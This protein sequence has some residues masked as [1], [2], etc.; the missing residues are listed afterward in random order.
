MAKPIFVT[1][2]TGN[3]GGQ[4]LREL[5]KTG[6]KVRV[7]VRSEEKANDFK[8]LGVQTAR[9]DFRDMPSIEAA[10]QGIDKAFSVSPMAADMVAM[11]I[12]FV[13]GAKKA[14]VKYIVRSS[15]M[16]ADAPQP[17]TLGQWHREM[18]KAL[19]DS[20]LAYTILRPNSF[21]QNYINMASHSIKKENAFY[22]P[23]GEG[24]IS[25]VDV[26]DL[27][28]VAAFVLTHRGYEGQAFNITGPEAISNYEIAQILSIITERKIN[29]HDIPEDAARQS[30]KGLGMPAVLVEALLELF[31]MN[32]AG[33]TAQVSDAVEKILGRKPIAF[34]QFVEDFAEA[35]K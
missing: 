6:V 13:K 24:K 34:K 17:I 15:A 32:K 33:Y 31:A 11:G 18:E 22:S 3:Q 16:G 7:D 27:A 28:A 26:R 21:M 8:K 2:A 12:N 9:M 4:V 29:Y 14:G 23:Q 19:E 5:L 35:F 10:L 30:L 1:G 25:L 20:G